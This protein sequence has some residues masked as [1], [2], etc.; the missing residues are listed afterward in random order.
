MGHLR[1]HGAEVIRDGAPQRLGEALPDALGPD[2]HG[3][4]PLS[5]VR[6]ISSS[7]ASAVSLLDTATGRS[8]ARLV[9]DTGSLNSMCVR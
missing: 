5:S 6:A 7:I 8:V 4:T 2:E 9:A 1:E 3:A